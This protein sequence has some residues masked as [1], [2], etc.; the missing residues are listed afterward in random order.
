MSL[1]G[2]SSFD[3]ILS[4]PVGQSVSSFDADVHHGAVAMVTGEGAM[5]Y[6]TAGNMIHV[7]T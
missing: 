7:L 1:D 2:G 4:L 5:F 6:G 3:P